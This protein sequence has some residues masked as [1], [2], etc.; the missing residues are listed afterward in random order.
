MVLQIPKISIWIQ[1][2]VFGNIHEISVLRT[3]LTS[4][5]SIKHVF[6]P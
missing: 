3:P 1:Q 5:K 2:S 4:M 6:T